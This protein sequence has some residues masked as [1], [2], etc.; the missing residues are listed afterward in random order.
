[1]PIS[2]ESYY[3]PLDTWFQ[4]DIFPV[5]EG[6]GVF[7]RDVSERRRASEFREELL[8]REQ[9]ARRESET[10]NRLKDEFLATLSHELRTPLNAITGWATLLAQGRLNEEEAAAAIETIQRNARAQAHLIEDLLD[11][12]RIIS[13]KLRLDVQAVELGPLVEAA[14]DA[15]RPAAEAKGVRLEVAIHARPAVVSGDSARLQQIAWN[16]LSNAIKFTPSGGCV[17]LVLQRVNSNVELTVSDTGIGIPPHMLQRIFDRFTQA[18]STSTREYHGLGLGLALVRH[19]VEAHGGSVS[20]SSAGEGHGATFTVSLPLRIVQE[21]GWLPEERRERSGEMAAS[22]EE[23]GSLHDVAV[24][25][26]EDDQQ[27][28]ELLLKM[29]S[30]MGASVR[31][32]S[33]A[34]EALTEL[35]RELPDVLLSDI[36]MPGE[37]GYSLIRKIRSRRDAAARLPAIAVTAY[38]R[39]EDRARALR[40]GFDNH[41]A[42]PL[43]VPELAAVISRA[44]APRRRTDRRGTAGTAV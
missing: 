11:V 24:L 32:A 7:Y 27:A 10:A 42:K 41:I 4:N 14:L 29:L 1:V 44:A 6:I 21:T 28:R 26:V 43:Y 37:D 40:E 15:V 5:E 35:D 25:V 17:Q 8:R 9:I 31:T 33:S 2:I 20:A 39:M 3:P 13:G 30:G 38:A 22:V 16:L 34:A 23:S 18:D 19:L 36:E 12:S